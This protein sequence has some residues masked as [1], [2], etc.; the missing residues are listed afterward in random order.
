MSQYIRDDGVKSTPTVVIDDGTQK[1]PF[2]G[3]DNIIKALELLK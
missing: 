3:V 1:Q 2:S